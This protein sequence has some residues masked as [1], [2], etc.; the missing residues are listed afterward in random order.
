MTCRR[1]LILDDQVMYGRSLVRALGATYDVK[2]A[3]TFAQ[4]RE[5]IGPNLDAVL[6]DVRLD[7]TNPQDWQGL[8][9]VAEARNQYSKLPIIAMS[10]LEDP[11]LEQAA[12]AAG[13][14]RFL[15]KPIVISHLK[16]LLEELL[17]T[18]P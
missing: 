16:A 18:K 11:N 9:F 8:R 4:A 13:A 2:V 7:E 5:I 3:T 17:K 12:I 10:A 14:T 1:L 6:A 15:R